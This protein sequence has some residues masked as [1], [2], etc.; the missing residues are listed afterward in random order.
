MGY[1]GCCDSD[2][3]STSAAASASNSGADSDLNCAS[4]SA[5]A[6]SSV[7]G[8]GSGSTD[9]SSFASVGDTVASAAG[10]LSARG[11]DIGGV[12]A[13]PLLLLRLSGAFS[14]DAIASLSGRR[15]KEDNEDL[16]GV[17]ALVF[18]PA[19]AASAAFVFIEWAAMM[20]HRSSPLD[21]SFIKDEN[22]AIAIRRD[23]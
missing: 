2:S 19:P 14:N 6:L 1:V 5:S 8:A 15:G 21:Q 17:S 7:S 10:V 23:I 16:S 12:V 22:I 20:P 13:G 4:A 9:D 11:V 18:L 3:D